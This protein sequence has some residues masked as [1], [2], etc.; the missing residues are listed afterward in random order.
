MC[1]SRRELSNAY[2]L[3]KF[4]VDTAENEPA[5][6]LQKFSKKSE[7]FANFENARSALRERA[8]RAL[9]RAQGEPARL[10]EARRRGA[11][12]EARRLQPRGDPREFPVLRGPPERP[13]SRVEYQN[14]FSIL[15]WKYP[16]HSKNNRWKYISGIIQ[17]AN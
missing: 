16:I 15:F 12:R 11:A 4:G 14:E 9:Q 5:K 2:L 17:S 8:L 6:N 13:H 7:N 1:R 3:A 10:P